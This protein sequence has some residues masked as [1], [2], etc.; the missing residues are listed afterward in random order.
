[1]KVSSISVICW[2]I[3]F[4][5]TLWTHNVYIAPTFFCTLW[6]GIIWLTEI[7]NQKDFVDEQIHFH[8]T[9]MV[10]LYLGLI[11]AC[12]AM[13]M[14]NTKRVI[15]VTIVSDNRFRPQI[16]FWM[17][18]LIVLRAS[19]AFIGKTKESLIFF[20][21][22][23]VLFL[24]SQKFETIQHQNFHLTVL[25]IS[26][27]SH[28]LFELFKYQIGYGWSCIF[29]VIWSLWWYAIYLFD[30]GQKKSKN[31]RLYFLSWIVHLTTYAGSDTIQ[32]IYEEDQPSKV[33]FYLLVQSLL[34]MIL[35]CSFT[36]KKY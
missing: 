30:K 15:D 25:N 24:L 21:S 32:Y 26:I 20:A 8:V 29:Y 3:G 2:L 16:L 9:H 17:F 1:M 18:S 23:V 34:F 5:V 4:W 14:Q 22:G 35:F 13:T 12:I 7:H 11:T 31:K 36:R 28:Y 27:L 6:F 33:L 10:S 19:V